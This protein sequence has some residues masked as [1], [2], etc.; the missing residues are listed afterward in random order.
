MQLYN[1]DRAVG[2]TNL[3]LLSLM[4]FRMTCD[5]CIIKGTN[6]IDRGGRH[7]SVEHDQ[8]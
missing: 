7:E 6:T 5:G 4:H 3:T 8:P 1:P 2:K